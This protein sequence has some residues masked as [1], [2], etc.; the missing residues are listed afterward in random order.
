MD[1][2]PQSS[3][4]S[5]GRLL[6]I[7]LVPLTRRGLSFTRDL[8]NSRTALLRSRCSD[9]NLF[10]TL[11]KLKK[12]NNCG[13]RGIKPQIMRII[14]W[15]RYSNRDLQ[16]KLQN[17]PPRK[18]SCIRQSHFHFAP[19]FLFSLSNGELICVALSRVERRKCWMTSSCISAHHSTFVHLWHY[20]T[21][22]RREKG[23]DESTST[24]TKCK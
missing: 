2:G 12:G 11:G 18:R 14:R 13:W 7:A 19:S 9:R 23:S 4:K 5:F 17:V 24:Q 3:I 1:M 22:R 16:L 15:I 20:Q 8:I 10:I 21:E 6:L